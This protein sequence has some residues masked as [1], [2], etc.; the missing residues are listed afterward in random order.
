MGATPSTTVEV[1]DQILFAEE[2]P[3][4][5]NNGD[6]SS[7]TPW[8]IMLVDDEPSVHQATKV[9]LKFF[10]FEG[11][12]LSFISAYSEQ[13]AKQL[14]AQ[15]PDTVLILLDVIM[16][17][18]D[19]GLKVAEYIRKELNNKA[20][21]IVLRT[22]QPGQVPEESVVV[23]Y[24]INDY[25]TKLELTQDK[26]FTTIIASIRAYRDLTALEESKIALSKA[27][28]ELETFNQNLE[29][30]IRDRTRLLAHEIEE[31]EKAEE[32]LKIYIHALTHDL[33]NPVTGMSTV[34]QTL[35]NKE[36][37]GD[38]PALEIPRSV[39]SRMK[40]GCDRQLKMIATL[41]ETYNIEIWGVSLQREHFEIRTLISEILADWQFRL[42]KKRVQVVTHIADDLPLIDGDRIQIWRVFENLIDNATKYNPP[43]ITIT[44]NIH[45]SEATPGFTQCLLSDNG[46]GIPS[47]QSSQLFQLY[48]RG[49]KS[50][51]TRGL[52]LGLYVCRSIIEAHGGNISVNSE[53]QKGSQFS[54]T[55]PHE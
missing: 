8:K 33:R 23:N 41:L 40:A 4:D 39:L 18:A 30:R 10:T 42:E 12:S 14:I 2:S 31:R 13:E 11:R 44:I 46:V 49:S 17:T 22:G 51:P 43:G 37:H 5:T 19:A 47:A 6:S 52:G 20:V 24:D 25:K 50:S 48:Q 29:E 54:F 35:L 15:N 27:N 21:R 7:E 16:R 9:A 34:L 32:A 3:I 26:L 36:V 53:A 45:E 1:D 38:P 55:L 28:L